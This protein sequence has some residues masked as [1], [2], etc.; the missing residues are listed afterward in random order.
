[1]VSCAT[2]GAMELGLRDRTA[3][4]GGGSSGLGL[5]AARALAAEG[6]RVAIGARDPAKLEAARSD[7]GEGAVAIEADLSTVDGAVASL[8]DDLLVSHLPPPGTPI[9]E[10]PAL[11]ILVGVAL[12]STIGA[13]IAISQLDSPTSVRFVP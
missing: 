4:V 13:A 10:E 2:I 6:V 7:L 12:L 11:W 9:Y 3:L 5:G 8:V 1:M